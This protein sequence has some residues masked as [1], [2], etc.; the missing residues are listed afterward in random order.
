ME[1]IAIIVCGWVNSE[2]SMMVCLGLTRNW[3]D[4]VGSDEQ[5]ILGKQSFWNECED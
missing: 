2:D 3:I 4:Y 5:F 1:E